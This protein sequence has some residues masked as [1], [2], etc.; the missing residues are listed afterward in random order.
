MKIIISTGKIKDYSLNKYL[1]ILIFI[2]I[3]ESI[4]AGLG[5][6]Y[7]NTQRLCNYSEN[8]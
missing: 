3:N 4:L 5:L 8:K 2:K 6:G 1:I 7:Q